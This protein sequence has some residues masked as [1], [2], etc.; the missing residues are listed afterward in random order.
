MFRRNSKKQLAEKQQQATIVEKPVEKPPVEKKIEKPPEKKI[1]K[2]TDSSPLPVPVYRAPT[3]HSSR[4][5]L[6]YNDATGPSCCF[7][8]TT[9]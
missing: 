4:I 9:F 2:A 8:N 5:I 3:V 7:F 1:E 6:A